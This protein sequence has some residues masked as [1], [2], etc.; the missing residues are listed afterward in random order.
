MYI[1]IHMF[2]P[3]GCMNVC[4]CFKSMSECVPD[5]YLWTCHVPSHMFMLTCV[6]I[7]LWRDP[8]MTII[9]FWGSRTSSYNDVTFWLKLASTFYALFLFTLPPTPYILG[10]FNCCFISYERSLRVKFT[11]SFALSLPLC[12]I[13]MG[14]PTWPQPWFPTEVGNS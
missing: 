1:Y 14:H 4:S 12:F 3:Y 10:E 11:A 2:L 7:L 6:P 5:C 13:T 8:C 9:M